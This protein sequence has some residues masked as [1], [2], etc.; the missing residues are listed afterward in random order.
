MG[1]PINNSLLDHQQ[2]KVEFIDGRI[3]ILTINTIAE[4]LL[5]QVDENGHRHLF[6]DEIEDHKIDE[7][8]IPKNQ[9]TYTTPSGT[10]RKRRTT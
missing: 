5:A 6:I 8:A 7:S 9:G 10:I 1:T 4:N 3:E 2:Y